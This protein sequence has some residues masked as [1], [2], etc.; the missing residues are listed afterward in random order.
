MHCAAEGG[1]EE[2]SFRM[3]TWNEINLFLLFAPTA[4]ALV[5]T[6]IEQSDKMEKEEG[7]SLQTHTWREGGGGEGAIGA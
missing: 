4:A 6:E 7:G 3:G 5:A 1:E 2:G